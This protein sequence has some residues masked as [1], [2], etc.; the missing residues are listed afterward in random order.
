MHQFSTL[1]YRLA[2]HILEQGEK[3]KKQAQEE[4]KKERKTETDHH[5]HHNIFTTL[6][7][8]RGL[9]A[10]HV[11]KPAGAIMSCIGIDVKFS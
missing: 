8:V 10:I 7:A 4:N 9:A 2:R 5:H 1:L 11:G 3:K 6:C